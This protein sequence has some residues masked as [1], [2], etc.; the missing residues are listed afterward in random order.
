MDDKR[1]ERSCPKCGYKLLGREGSVIMCLNP[2]C[3]WAIQS[4][5]QEDSNIPLF[6]DL[7]KQ[8]NGQ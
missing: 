7:Q 5:R 8:F 4:K 1:I 2:N 3:D 6:T